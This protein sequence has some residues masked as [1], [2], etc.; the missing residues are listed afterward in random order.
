MGSIRWIPKC[1][2]K[3]WRLGLRPRPPKARESAFGACQSDICRLGNGVN[4]ILKW[5]P[6]TPKYSQKRWRLGL[7]S[8]PPLARERAPSTLASLTRRWELRGTNSHLRPRRHKPSVRHCI[9]HAL[10]GRRYVQR[11]GCFISRHMGVA[12]EAGS[13]RRVSVAGSHGP[14]KPA[15]SAFLPISAGK[16]S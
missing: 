2:K 13:N 3:R 7:R 14:A 9:R 15:F 5:A 11:L 12:G 1:S 16:A 8:R 6:F 4:A 10:Y